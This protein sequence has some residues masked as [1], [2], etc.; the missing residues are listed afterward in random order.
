MA[1]ALRLGPGHVA[2]LV[3]AFASEFMRE[4]YEKD[5][6]TG[7]RVFAQGGRSGIF[8][9]GELCT[10]AEVDAQAL[11]RRL[12]AEIGVTE[13]V[14]VFPEIESV[15]RSV[16]PFVGSCQ[17]EY[18]SSYVVRRTVSQQAEALDALERVYDALEE[19]RR[20]QD[21]WFWLSPCYE[22]LYNHEQKE[23]R[24]VFLKTALSEAE[25]ERLKAFFLL[26]EP[27]LSASWLWREEGL[28][29]KVAASS[30]VAFACGGIT[31]LPQIGSQSGC[32]LRHPRVFGRYL[33]DR[34]G[35]R[36]LEG[37][38]AEALL[39]QAVW[40]TFSSRPQILSARTNRGASKIDDVMLDRLDLLQ[41]IPTDV[42]VNRLFSGRGLWTR[43]KSSI[44][45]P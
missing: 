26:F 9:S 14:P 4:L 30:D 8:L 12:W 15:Q 5:P 20:T 6:E 36:L 33:L 45:V 13:V 44:P 24:A 3:S 25:D 43:Q 1:V 10:R 34:E 29:P 23:L 22:L 37:D 28:W 2:S 7:G 39:L 17:T 21:E 32:I 38:D 18:V 40:P 31:H 19:K 41:E 11:A 27:E 35:R 42:S 16:A